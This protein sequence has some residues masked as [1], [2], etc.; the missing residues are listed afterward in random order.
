MADVA[1]SEDVRALAGAVQT[2][3]AASGTTIRVDMGLASFATVRHR[4]GPILHL[5][6]EG[7]VR[8]A[9]L[10][11]AASLAQEWLSN[12]ARCNTCALTSARVGLALALG[13][14][15]F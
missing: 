2:A 12:R 4:A 8:A 5:G 14:V 13:C 10:D 1:M 3:L 15:G 9:D 7:G 6:V 11:A